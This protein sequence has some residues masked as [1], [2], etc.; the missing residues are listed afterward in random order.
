MLPR[1]EVL[2]LRKKMRLLLPLVWLLAAPPVP[3]ALVE[4]DFVPCMAAPE[5][6]LLYTV[7]PGDTLYAIARR[8]GL[9]CELLLALNPDLSARNLSVGTKVALPPSS[10]RTIPATVSRGSRPLHLAADG[11]HHL[12]LWPPQF[13]HPPRNR[14]CRQHRR[15][16]TGLSRG[17][18]PESRPPR[19][20][21]QLHSGGSW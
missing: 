6:G 9:S 5:A 10:R 11:D 20:L 14:H 15:P 8:Y 18:R 17:N 19:N 21:R 4:G 3:A 16:G 13:R 12:S 2:F 1:N 7:Q